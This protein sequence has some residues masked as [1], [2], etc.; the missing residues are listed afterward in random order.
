MR[1]WSHARVAAGMVL[2]AWATLFWFLLA[3]DRTM[4]YLSTR[5]A[6]LVPMGAII[7]TAAAIGRLASAR[8]PEPEPLGDRECWAL[9]V[10]VLPVVI[11]LALPPVTLGAYAAGKRSSFSGST[12]GASARV[13][14]GPIDFVDIAASQTTKEGQ[15]ALRA[16]AGEVVTLEGFVTLVAG[17]GPDEFRLTRFI[18]TCCVADATIAQ[19]RVVGA[20]PGSVTSDGWVSVTGRIYPLGNDVLIA[21][22]GAPQQ[23]PVPD[24]PYLTP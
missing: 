22:N 15:A 8:V 12:L 7:A 4:L 20:P 16:R 14:S 18:I 1:R 6:W 5:T 19:V 3:T 13:V 9:G 17:D 10:V 21:A 2:A 24:D 11:L 23:I